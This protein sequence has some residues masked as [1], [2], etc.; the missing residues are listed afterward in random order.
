MYDR[1]YISQ[2]RRVTDYI[3]LYRSLKLVRGPSFFKI[4]A[5]NLPLI[6]QIYGTI[7]TLSNNISY[8]IKFCTMHSIF[9]KEKSNQ[10]FG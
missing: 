6:T 10:N 1:M 3:H 2:K 4:V 8:A 9:Q 5:R 7:E